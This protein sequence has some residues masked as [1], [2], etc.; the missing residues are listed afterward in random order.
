MRHLSM[1]L[2]SGFFMIAGM[3][4]YMG[5]DLGLTLFLA[6]FFL[7]INGIMQVLDSSK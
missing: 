6:G 1:G 4:A 7:F 3:R 2:A 5:N